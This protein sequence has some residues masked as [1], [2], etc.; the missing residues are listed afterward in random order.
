[1]Q[2]HVL[3]RRNYEGVIDLVSYNF[4]YKKNTIIYSIFDAENRL[5]KKVNNKSTLFFKIRSKKCVV[6]FKNRKSHTHDMEAMGLL[7][8]YTFI[9][10][11]T[12]AK[13][14]SFAVPIT[15]SCIKI[16]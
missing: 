12:F 2:L 4:F 6:C 14:I 10:A 16:V 13:L 3:Y 15:I 1:M 5:L 7:K 9:P 11:I 8:Y